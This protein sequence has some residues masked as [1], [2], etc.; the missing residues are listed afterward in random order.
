MEAGGKVNE[1][2]REFGIFDAAY[3]NWKSKCSLSSLWLVAGV[4]IFHSDLGRWYWWTH[5]GGTTTSRINSRK[6]EY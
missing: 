2:C 6:T 5:M 4:A 1:V 3:Y